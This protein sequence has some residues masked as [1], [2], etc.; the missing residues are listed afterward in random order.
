MRIKD[1]R[2]NKMCEVPRRFVIVGADVEVLMSLFR[3]ENVSIPMDNVLTE[4]YSRLK[5]MITNSDRKLD[6]DS[7]AV[8]ALCNSISVQRW[9]SNTLHNPESLS[10]CPC[11]EQFRPQN[12]LLLIRR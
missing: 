8:A 1:L 11:F 7:I 4:N 10:L 5:M 3:D 12:L 6:C 2:D 9:H